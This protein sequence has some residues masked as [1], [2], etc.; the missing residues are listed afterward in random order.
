MPDQE[1]LYEKWLPV[2][3]QRIPPIQMED[4]QRP[5][6]SEA[7]LW[8][9]VL[10]YTFLDISGNYSL[11]QIDA[12]DFILSDRCESICQMCGLDYDYILSKAAKSWALSSS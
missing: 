1:S 9:R 12:L 8:G 4:I 2:K 11:E 6:L 10:H 5:L 3:H 7:A